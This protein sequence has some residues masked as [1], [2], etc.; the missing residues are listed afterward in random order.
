[1]GRPKGVGNKTPAELKVD[2]DML[3]KKAEMQELERKRRELA[4]QRQTG[5]KSGK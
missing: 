2:A 3:R 4:L 1:M 5:A